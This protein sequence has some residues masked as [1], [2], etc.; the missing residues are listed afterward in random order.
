MAL[1]EF[2]SF[3]P[4][5]AVVAVDFPLTDGGH[6][7][8]QIT[9]WRR[10]AP[11]PVV[12]IDKAHLGAPTGVAAIL[13]LGVNAYVA[14]PLKGTELLAKLGSL[15]AAASARDAPKGL[16]LTL[17]RSPLLTGNLKDGSLSGVLHSM[18]RLGRDGILVITSQKSTRRIF[19]RE[20]VPVNC[21]SSSR[22]ESLLHY[23]KQSGLLSAEQEERVLSL[24][25]N[26][27]LIG[28]AIA[29]AGIAIEAEELLSRAREHVRR[30]V[31][32]LV[33]M[34]SGGYAFYAGSEFLSE[35]ETF[36]IAPLV[37]ILQGARQ[38]FPLKYF[39]AALRPKLDKYPVRSAS[40][41]ADV[42]DLG[43]EPT[44]LSLVMHLDGTASLREV[45]AH[46]R[47]DLRLSSSLMW[48]LTL[49]GDVEFRDEPA[50]GAGQSEPM[51]IEAA[52]VRR[53]KPM[54]EETLTEL[55][56]SAVK[57]LTG[58]YFGALGL[59][60][61]ADAEAV[62]KAYRDMSAKFHPD[63]YAEFDASSIAGLLADVQE[64]LSAAHKVLSV[65]DKR[66]SYL[67]YLL[68]RLESGR[69]QP[70]NVD[71]EI[72]LRRGL[73]ALSKQDFRSAVQHFEEATRLNPREPEYYCCLAW[74]NYRL[75][76]GERSERAKEAKRLLKKALALDSTSLRAETLYA[77]VE[78]EVG[79]VPAA[80]QRLLTVLRNHP[81]L[82]IAK[83]ALRAVGK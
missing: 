66:R 59:D 30:R 25:A 33:G 21:D 13:E 23:L 44:E 73:N 7:A 81:D 41:A 75:R 5:A 34:A 47:L 77:I 55:Q 42:P 74:A 69:T 24:L 36:K 4:D 40:F 39:S 60:I 53:R 80:R 54:P 2:I 20:G 62:E 70:V 82:Q 14:D 65:D 18:Y 3:G 61:A 46:G 83:A 27:A 45:L 11:V 56:E 63:S 38:A 29:G 16:Q 52:P 9:A 72:A 37:P 26:G 1:E 12:A 48:W 15:L 57:I 10:S 32:Q 64:K 22:R 19:F 79:E 28:A 43:L 50:V 6:L 68:T 17:S 67:E 71:A 31:A 35:V 8:H 58:S 51:P 76:S 78:G 49:T